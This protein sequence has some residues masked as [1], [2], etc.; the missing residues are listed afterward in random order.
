MSFLER[1]TGLY[2][3]ISSNTSPN[4]SQP[5]IGPS[6]N[7]GDEEPIEYEESGDMTDTDH[8]DLSHFVKVEQQQDEIIPKKKKRTAT[9]A[10]GVPAPMPEYL[11]SARKC[12]KRER[13]KDPMWMFCKSLLP[14]IN[15]LNNRRKR[16]FKI[17][18]MS[19]LNNLLDDQEDEDEQFSSGWASVDSFR[20][21]SNS[22]F[23]APNESEINSYRNLETLQQ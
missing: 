1:F 9:S 2:R 7:S 12:R 8:Q 23:G 4:S 15:K 6:Y 3:K 18:V 14:D 19:Q 17:S 20:P 5:N 11:H 21:T 22:R 10:D 16:Q 13:N